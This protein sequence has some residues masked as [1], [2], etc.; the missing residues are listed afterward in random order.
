MGQD[1]KSTGNDMAAKSVKGD[2]LEAGRAAA[3][4]R[5]EWPTLAAIVAVALLALVA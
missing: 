3:L 1:G 2:M 5:S 4:L